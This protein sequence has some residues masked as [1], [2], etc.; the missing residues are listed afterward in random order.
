MLTEQNLLGY[1]LVKTTHTYACWEV[2]IYGNIKFYILL[3]PMLIAK[4][5]CLRGM[6]FLHGWLNVIFD[7]YGERIVGRL[8]GWRL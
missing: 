6:I 4:M 8:M 5:Y 3:H 1:S 2:A 7:A